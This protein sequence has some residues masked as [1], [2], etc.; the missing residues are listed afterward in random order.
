M[1]FLRRDRVT[2]VEEMTKRVRETSLTS[3]LYEG[4]TADILSNV[5]RRDDRDRIQVT[6]KLM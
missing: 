1:K 6:Q 3:V 2:G 5:F 4:E